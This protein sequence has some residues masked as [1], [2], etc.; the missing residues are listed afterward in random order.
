MRVYEIAKK[1][2]MSNK[3][4]MVILSELGVKATNAKSSLSPDDIDIVKKY[5]T[6]NIKNKDE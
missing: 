2:D 1:Y 5:F 3:D 4:F 6:R